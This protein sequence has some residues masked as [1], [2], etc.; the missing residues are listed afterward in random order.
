[1]WECEWLCFFWILNDITWRARKQ[2]NERKINNKF[3]LPPTSPVRHSFTSLAHVT[4]NIIVFGKT[5]M[6]HTPSDI[7][8]HFE[9]KLIKQRFRFFFSRQIYYRRPEYHRHRSC[10]HSFG[11]LSFVSW[12]GLLSF[13]NHPTAKLTTSRGWLT[14]SLLCAIRI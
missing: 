13:S 9:A 7:H 12:E 3:T 14:H 2:T 11:C 10:W 1:M 4:W 6:P 8:L 5:Q